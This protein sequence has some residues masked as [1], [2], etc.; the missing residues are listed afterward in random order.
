M[1]KT[2]GEFRS[3]QRIEKA[4]A[5]CAFE[6]TPEF[7]FLLTVKEKNGNEKPRGAFRKKLPSG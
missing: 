3:L 2:E 4:S 6:A 1:F 7:L 5:S